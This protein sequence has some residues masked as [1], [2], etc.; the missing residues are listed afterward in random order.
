MGALRISVLGTVQVDRGGVPLRLGPRLVGLLS[1]LVMEV[2]RPV[3]AARLMKLLWADRVP[4]AATLRSHVSHLR[5]AL[6]PDRSESNLLVWVGSGCGAGYQLNLPPDRIDAWRF[7]HGYAEGRRLISDG[8]TERAAAVLGAALALWRGPAYA[9]VADQPFAVREIAR[10][11]S[12]RRSASRAYAEALCAS[13]RHA[14]AIDHLTG[15]IA[16]QPYDEALRRMLALALY[17][18]QRVDEAAQVCRDGL[19]LLRAR[20]IEA[21]ELERVQRA[22]LRRDS[23]ATASPVPTTPCL[24]PP[25][26]VRFV[27]RAE[28]I[29]RARRHLCDPASAGEPL[30]VTGPAG[31]GKSTFAVRLAHEVA[32]RFPDGQLYVN[33]RGFDPAGP[34]L[35]PEEAIQGFLD[36]LNVPPQR[37]PVTLEAQ[38]GLYRGLLAARRI[39][40]VL[41][42]ARDAAQVRPLLPGSPSCGA[43]ITS[44]NQMAGLATVDGANTLALDLLTPAE[45]RLLLARRMG[46]EWLGT[47]PAAVDEI[48]EACAGLPLALAVVAARAQMNPR[49]ALRALAAQ[50]HDARVRLDAFVNGDAEN[51]VRAAFSWSYQ[52]LADDSAR[53]FRMVS[54]A[55]GPDVTAPAAAALANLPV[56]EAA[57]LLADLC[58]LH[59]ITEH[60]PGR[61]M[62]HDLLRSYATELAHAIDSPAERKAAQFRCLASYLHTAR[63]AA[64][65]LDPHRDA[66][67]LPG[68]A[69]VAGS[70][71]LADHVA[72]LAWFTAEHE[73]LLGAVDLA[74]RAGL[75]AY[76]WQL[77][78]ACETF[79]DYQGHWYDWLR[80]QRTALDAARRLGDRS[81]QAAS[82]R[83]L[84]VVHTQMGRLDDGHLHFR[85]ALKLYRE[86]DDPVGQA[87]AHRGLGWVCDQQG[88]PRDALDH[89][90]RALL[91]YQR[92]GHRAGQAMVRNNIGWL[93]GMLGDHRRAVENCAQAV[94]LN[95]EVGDPH[96][97]AAA[98]DSLAMAHHHLGAYAEA[99]AYFELALE[100]V[101]GFGDRYNEAGILDHLGDTYRAAGDP[102]AARTV[103]RHALHIAE[104]LG[105]PAVPDLR[106]KIEALQSLSTGGR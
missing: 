79:L 83:S 26:P 5:R 80:T 39:L 70:E 59:L 24:L 96:G 9:D 64:R 90:E 60:M 97:Q 66:V 94:A 101:R 62:F 103:W 50:L 74:A 106:R 100:L 10:L 48:V 20:G 57:L 82:H 53:L 22:I 21:P 93:H 32:N 38:V 95:Q 6:A 92:A 75:D 77:A 68:G 104:E 71:D 16:D 19:R 30:V 69:V 3:P 84:G 73:V 7:E 54:L 18:E 46:A 89:N 25:N 55:P 2:S 45:A 28:E 29:E 67:P 56:R 17:A 98:W 31:V 52:A 12:M 41:D 37:M 86:V 35:A 44:R 78:W 87:H 15:A 47:D 4:S 14:E 42:N 34:A 11:D 33:L 88:R 27:A 81:R 49:F 72:A 105:H 61:Y 13:G 43:V 91:L 40:V 102:P 51:D 85:E 36:A 23:T 8:A 63:R 99:I 76:A 65:L 58:R 1:V